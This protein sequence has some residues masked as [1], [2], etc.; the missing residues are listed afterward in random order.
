MIHWGFLAPL[1]YLLKARS[2]DFP[3]FSRLEFVADGCSYRWFFTIKFQRLA[4]YPSLRLIYT[5][6]VLLELPLVYANQIYREGPFLN[7][8]PTRLSCQAPKL[9]QY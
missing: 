3:Q 7:H 5:V 6:R 2:D 8:L 9:L 1:L 4:T